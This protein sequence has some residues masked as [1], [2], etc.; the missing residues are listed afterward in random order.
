MI[1]FREVNFLE[2]SSGT[3]KNFFEECA[4]NGGKLKYLEIMGKRKLSQEHFD[5]AEQFGVQL[6]NLR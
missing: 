4:N 5:V 6:I 1:Q 2:I 3:L